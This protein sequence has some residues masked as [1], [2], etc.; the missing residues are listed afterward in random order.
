[1]AE[2]FRMGQELDLA[3]SH[4][5]EHCLGLNSQPRKD[6]VT[7]QTEPELDLVT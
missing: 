4:C 3:L 2:V 6:L 7:R 5:P 1:M